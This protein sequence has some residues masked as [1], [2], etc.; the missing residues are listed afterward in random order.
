MQY[1]ARNTATRDICDVK[2]GIPIGGVDAS[3]VSINNSYAIKVDSFSMPA[4]TRGSGE[5]GPMLTAMLQVRN[6][7]LPTPRS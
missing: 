3:Q 5:Q 7:S 6:T 2:V 1:R 4:T